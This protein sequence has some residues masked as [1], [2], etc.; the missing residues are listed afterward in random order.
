MGFRAGG[1]RRRFFMSHVNPSNLLLAS[2]RVRDSVERVARDSVE[3]LDSRRS[4][5][6]HK[7]VRDSFFRHVS[8]LSFCSR[9]SRGY[10]PARGEN[11]SENYGGGRIGQKG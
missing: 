6:I 10:L 3:S 2:N 1:K 8:P 7:Q 5:G 4:K 9:F 11:K